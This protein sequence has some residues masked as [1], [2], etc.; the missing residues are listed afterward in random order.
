MFMHIFQM[1]APQG[2]DAVT[3]TGKSSEYKGTLPGGV[4]PP[5]HVS[6]GLTGE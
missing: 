2:D 1:E 3:C 5:P 4:A 6:L